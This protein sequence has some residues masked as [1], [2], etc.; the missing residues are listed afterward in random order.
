MALGIACLLSDDPLEARAL[1]QRLD[2]INAERREMQQQML[3]QAEALVARWLEAH[4]GSLPHGLCVFDPEWHPGVI[5]LLASRLKDR[6][7]R[8]VIAFAPGGPDGLL[9]GSARSIP[10]FHLRDALADI[11]TRHPDLLGRFG[12]H[13]MAAGLS[14]APE[15]FDRFA[16][17]FDA[18]TRERVDA[19][20][21]QAEL[22]SDGA[23]GRREIDRELAEVLRLGG[24]WGQGF[25]EPQFDGEFAVESWRVVG[26][27][28]LKLRLRHEQ[29]GEP[30]DAIQFG[31]WQG[32]PPSARLQ[33]VY[34]LDLDDWRDRRGVQL[35]IRHRASI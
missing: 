16:A 6:L 28:H 12:G 10:G 17:A 9:R 4:G 3:D 35:L 30:L 18:I 26:A 27:A 15:N 7:H 20:M 2:T 25:A 1:A 33:L 8:P 13:A 11:A 21:L 14:L 31:G 29:G 24:P 23:L 22:W 34:Q 32:E 19:A 5:G